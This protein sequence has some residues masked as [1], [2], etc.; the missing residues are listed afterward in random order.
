MI[1]HRRTAGWQLLAPALTVAA[2]LL[3][4]GCGAGEQPATKAT[5]RDVAGNGSAAPAHALLPQDIKDSGKVRIG[6]A[7]TAPPFSYAEPGGDFA[8]LVPE[9]AIAAQKQLGVDIEIVDTAYPD[10]VPAL[11]AGKIDM[12][13]GATGVSPA[14]EKVIDLVSYIRSA[15]A[16]M[17][18]K[19]DP[20]SITSNEDFCGHVIGTIKG[21][22]LQKWLEKQAAECESAG[23]PMEA[24]LYDTSSGATAQLQAGQ[25]DALLGIDMLQRYIAET[26]DG[27]NRFEMLD[28]K[29]VPTFYGIGF[30]KG[31]TPLEEAF[32]KAI[33][34]VIENGDY[35]AVVKKYKAEGYAITAD[36]VVINPAAKGLVAK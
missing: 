11:Q 10:Q 2:A 16:P 35:A 13:W 33:Q 21:G 8:G 5:G 12:I 18:M 7:S 24:K 14:R 23:K 22:D 29:V 6:M 28:F 27:G 20:I 3:L 30:T 17:V 15:A 34:L 26:A 36:Q 31:E 9:L 25:I 4:T 32:A 1:A 19:S